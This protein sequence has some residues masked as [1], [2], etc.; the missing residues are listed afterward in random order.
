[1]T[2]LMLVF[3]IFLP[4][5][6]LALY[7]IICYCIN[8]SSEILHI[9]HTIRDLVSRSAT[10]TPA[11]SVSL[12]RHHRGFKMLLDDHSTLTSE[13]KQFHDGHIQLTSKEI[14][15]KKAEA[16]IG[17]WLSMPPNTRISLWSWVRMISSVP[18]TSTSTSF[19]TL[20][21]PSNSK[22]KGF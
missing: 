2:S 20:L 9:T 5:L 18:S 21:F 7:Y 12:N 10:C 22:E 11:N 13:L 19:V 6:E 4:S 14:V 15:S 17:A 16:I 1:M 3:F 8:Q